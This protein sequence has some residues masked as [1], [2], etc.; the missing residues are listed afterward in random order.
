MSDDH[1]HQLPVMNAPFVPAKSAAGF[2]VGMSFSEA[3]SRISA[4]DKITFDERNMASIDYDNF[5][6]K[7]EGW[8]SHI[9]KNIQDQSTKKQIVFRSKIVVLNFASNDILYRIV[10]GG[11]Y[12]SKIGGVGTG[13]DIAQIGAGYSV[14]FNP[15]EDDF[16]LYKDGEWVPGLHFW[17]DAM[18]PL[19]LVPHQVIN[20]VSIHDVSLAG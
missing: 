18:Q 5:I 14:E 13:D 11:D 15:V 16:I 1:S 3:V 9:Q 10:V 20:F 19:N 7:N 8:V 6:E 17:T 4:Q 2:V 12:Q